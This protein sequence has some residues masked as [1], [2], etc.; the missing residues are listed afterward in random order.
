MR[1]KKKIYLAYGSNL[2]L[3]QMKLRCPEAK[4]LGG[5]VLED[6]ALVFRGG[7][8]RAVADITPRQG[9]QVPALL[10][11]ITP[12]DEA[13][14]D[15]YEGWPRLYVKKTLTVIFGGKP[16][17]AMAYVMSEGQSLGYPGRDYLWVIMR[18][19]QTA[20]FDT[21]TLMEAASRSAQKAGSEKQREAT[22]DASKNNGGNM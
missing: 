8:D 6:Y 20:G 1:N 11:E 4:V 9:G 16:I 19:Y 10:W 12:S 14:L 17:E 22:G 15:L 18:G 5:A 2:N 7:D 3:E 21:E 13:A